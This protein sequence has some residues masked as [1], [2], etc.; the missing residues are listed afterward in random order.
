M[1]LK[2]LSLGAGP[3]KGVRRV[4]RYSILTTS[5]KKLQEEEEN[6]QC[7]NL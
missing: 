3:P 4:T 6:K 2:V 1:V 5:Y 7:V